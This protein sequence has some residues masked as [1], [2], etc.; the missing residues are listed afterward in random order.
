MRRKARRKRRLRQRN[1]PCVWP[2]PPT[3]SPLRHDEGRQLGQAL[4]E[5][6]LQGYRIEA[7][8][9]TSPLSSAVGVASA[10]G[11]TLAT[12]AN[13]AWDIAAGSSPLRREPP[14]A[15]LAMTSA[16]RSVM[17]RHERQWTWRFLRGPRARRRAPDLGGLSRP[18]AY[19]RWRRT[20][21]GFA[22]RRRFHVDEGLSPWFSPNRNRW[23]STRWTR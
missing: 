10:L 15:R 19:L 1:C 11:Q 9:L 7:L 4:L 2:P 20:G 16:A 21:R 22:R 12:A 18:T 5:V 14:T 3:T 6:V 23:F 13:A 17:S 8:D